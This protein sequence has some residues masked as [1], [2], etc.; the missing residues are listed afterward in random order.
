MIGLEAGVVNALWKRFGPGQFLVY[1]YDGGLP[2]VELREDGSVEGTCLYGPF[3]LVYRYTETGQGYSAYGFDPF[4]N[5]AVMQYQTQTVIRNRAVYDSFGR[6]L[7]DRLAST[8][9]AWAPPVDDVGTMSQWG[10]LADIEFRRQRDGALLRAFDGLAQTG[11]A[12]WADPRTGKSLDRNPALNAYRPVHIGDAI[13]GLE[14]GVVNALWKSVA[15]PIVDDGLKARGLTNLNPA[16]QKVR[17]RFLNPYQIDQSNP[18]QR[19]F[20]ISGEGVGTAIG[21]VGGAR[22]AG[23]LNAGRAPSASRVFRAPQNWGKTTS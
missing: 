18:I 14:A 4:G 6:L 5:A 23:G 8:P 9:N 11:P 7:E 3:G 17:D 12:T 2:L 16:Q 13:I 1:L 10:G 15:A 22:G 20:A 21:A 19:G